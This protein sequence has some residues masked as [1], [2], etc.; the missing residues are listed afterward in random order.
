VELAAEGAEVT[1]GPSNRVRVTV[2]AGE[3]VEIPVSLE[4]AAEIEDNL[5]L[6]IVSP[7]LETIER[8]FNLPKRA[9]LA[10]PTAGGEIL[11]MRVEWSGNL[12]ADCQLSVRGGHLVL[13]ASVDDTDVAIDTKA[14]WEAS[15]ISLGIKDPLLPEAP[16]IPIVI[17][18][19]PANPQVCFWS[20]RFSR[21][22]SVPDSSATVC[23]DANGYKLSLR[24]SF[25][26]AGIKPGSPFL[27][28]A[29]FCVN[30]LGTAH[31]RISASWQGSWGPMYPDQSRFALLTPSA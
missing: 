7:A 4:V 23:K 19:D 20:N 30:A 28:E 13:E 21:G 11:P 29:T 2:A 22:E 27:F 17:L 31:G 24:L 18:P 5:K 6:S 15:A 26:Q 12:V 9:R 10:I 16:V 8:D 1:F 3:R 14:F 25:E